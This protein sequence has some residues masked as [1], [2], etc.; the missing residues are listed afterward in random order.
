[1][2]N[3]TFWNAFYS[4]TFANT[5][6]SA[7]AL[8]AEPS[9][10][11]AWVLHKLNLLRPQVKA[12]ENDMLNWSG[13]AQGDMFRLLDLGCG[14]GRDTF[15]FGWLGM[16]ATGL[17]FSDIVIA[18]NRKVRIQNVEFIK[19]DISCV[20][21]EIF[22]NRTINMVY[23]R[24]SMDELYP[25]SFR[26]TLAWAHFVL[27]VGSH[28]C[29][30]VRTKADPKYGRGVAG[31]TKGTYYD[32]FDEDMF[33]HFFTQEEL[34]AD[35]KAT[36]FAIEAMENDVDNGERGKVLRVIASKLGVENPSE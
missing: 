11:A 19:Q 1:M 12:F 34:L 8:E 9:P 28:L 24:L 32:E 10:F 25:K 23:A 36:N 27:K 26:E 17:D 13:D 18:R 15:Y 33:R 2:T 30:E 16:K 29:L 31:K 35:L 4:Y 5:N 14:N 21:R 7:N 6:E 20:S 3:Y 22:K